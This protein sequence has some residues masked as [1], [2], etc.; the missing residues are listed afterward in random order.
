MRITVQSDTVASVIKLADNSLMPPTVFRFY[1]PIDSLFGIISKQQF[2]SVIVKY[3]G[4][5][6][7]PEVLDIDPQNHPVDGGVLYQTTNLQVK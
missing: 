2:D 3:N 1:H 7:Y 4:I 5:Y 6:G